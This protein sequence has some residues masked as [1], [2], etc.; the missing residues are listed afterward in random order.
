[1]RN[2]RAGRASELEGRARRRML[3]AAAIAILGLASAWVGSN[4]AYELA[5][6]QIA[7]PS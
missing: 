6:I 4:Y 5:R 2:K 7:A 1:M 3:V